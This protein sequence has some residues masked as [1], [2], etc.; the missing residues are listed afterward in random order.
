MANA[1][2]TPYLSSSRLS[3]YDWCP[4]LYE[5]RYVLG[6]V[7]PPTPERLFG[8]AVHAGLEAHFR[9]DRNPI[10]AFLRRWSEAQQEIRDWDEALL[11]FGQGLKDRGIELICEVQNLGLEGI[12]EAH[13]MFS[14]PDIYLPFTGYI[15]LVTAGHLY[16]FKTAGYGWTQ[17]KA[18]QQVWQPAIYSAAYAWEKGFTPQFTYVVL[19]RIPGPVQLLDGSRTG[20]VIDAV[21]GEALARLKAID[22]GEF[23]CRCG[24]HD[25][26]TPPGERR[27]YVS[28]GMW[29][30]WSER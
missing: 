19:P 8:V 29:Q 18:D 26:E 20:L 15:D 9:G 7:E 21:F 2:H 5:Q 24:K 11:P 23:A 4:A 10:A 12:P 22:A 6:L 16:D 25:T 30:R 28:T 14:H 1:H 13:V 17:A 27:R 3:T